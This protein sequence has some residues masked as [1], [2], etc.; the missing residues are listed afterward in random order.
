[1]TFFINA[2]LATS[3]TYKAR[4]RPTRYTE[5]LDI[6]MSVLNLSDMDLFTYLLM[7]SSL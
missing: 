5:M 1:M 6:K 3:L 4:I 2:N 7:S